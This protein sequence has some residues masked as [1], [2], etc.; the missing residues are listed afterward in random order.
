MKS[1][2]GVGRGFVAFAAV[3]VCGLLGAGLEFWIVAP[4]FSHPP[5]GNWLEQ[6]FT[7]LTIVCLWVIATLPGLVVGLVVGSSI[8]V[9]TLII[10][11]RRERTRIMERASRR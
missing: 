11:N 1:L 10:L 7:P 3:V 2:P 6:V 5:P 8:A 4:D 9:P